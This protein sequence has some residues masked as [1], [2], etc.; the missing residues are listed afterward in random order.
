MI[1]VAATAIGFLAKS[2]DFDLNFD[3]RTLRIL[4]SVTVIF[5]DLFIVCVN[6]ALQRVEK[7]FHTV[8]I[9]AR[10]PGP[11]NFYG[12]SDITHD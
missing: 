1:A 3:T 5:D 2:E 6:D 4:E 11:K 9:I 10:P 7:N 12:Y 8:V